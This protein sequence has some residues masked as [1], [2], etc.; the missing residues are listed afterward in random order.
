MRLYLSPPIWRFL[1]I[2]T[3]QLA[4]NAHYSIQL[5]LFHNSTK[6][7]KELIRGNDNDAEHEMR[8]DL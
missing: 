7:V 8:H 3:H 1:G 6:Q 2:D 4:Y 5:L